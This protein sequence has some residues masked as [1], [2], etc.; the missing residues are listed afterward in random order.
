MQSDKGLKVLNRIPYDSD[1]TLG[2]SYN[3]LVWLTGE[4]GFTHGGTDGAALTLNAPAVAESKEATLSPE[5]LHFRSRT[6]MELMSRAQTKGAA[7]YE[8]YIKRLMINSRQAF[9]H[10]LDMRLIYGGL[11]IG[12]VVTGDAGAATTWAPTIS[13]NTWAPGAWIGKRNCAFDA[14]DSTTKL[15]S[16]ADLVCAGVNVHTRVISFTG[17]SGD[18]TAIKAI[19]TNGSTVKLYY[20]GAYSTSAIGLKTVA[21]LTSSSGNYLGIACGTYTDFWTG[22]QQTWD[23]SA[24]DFTWTILQNGL[25]ESFNK[26]RGGNRIALVP[27]GVWKT[28]NSSLD[29]LRAFDSSYS[30]SKV[31]MGHK[32]DAITYHSLGFRVTVEC[33]RN[34]MGGDVIVYP[35]PGSDDTEDG[36]SG[37]VR[38]I[39]SSNVTFNLPD[40]GNEMFVQVYGTNLVEHGAFSDQALWA[41]CPPDFLIFNND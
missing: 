2:A 29:A 1:V 6:T 41:P 38:R 23:A 22:V 17:A 12:T 31:E 36:M 21:K 30:V 40:K 14:Y 10:R 8:N 39:G 7:S 4:H 28:L 3:E 18:I 11:S 32:I 35:D 33:S 34:V 20:K 37:D 15:N 9:D 25:E 26:G 19:G 13:T 5:S 27:P 24:E 16:T